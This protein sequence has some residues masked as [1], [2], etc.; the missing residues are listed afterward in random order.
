MWAVGRDWDGMLPPGHSARWWFGVGR[1][2]N[3]LLYVS[4]R[5]EPFQLQ[6]LIQ[7]I[8]CR[9]SCKTKQVWVTQGLQGVLHRLAMRMGGGPPQVFP[10][11]KASRGWRWWRDAQIPLLTFLIYLLQHTLPLTLFNLFHLKLSYSL[12]GC[13]CWNVNSQRAEIL[14]D[15]HH[16]VPS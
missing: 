4:L 3:T 12:M 1:S 5:G 14:S 6:L 7:S 15:H 9:G 13:L 8:V 16:C 10:G 11:T 2:I